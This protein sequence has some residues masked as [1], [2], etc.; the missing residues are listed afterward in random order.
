M[1]SFAFPLGVCWRDVMASVMTL[2][3]ADAQTAGDFMACVMILLPPHYGPPAISNTPNSFLGMCT[4]LEFSFCNFRCLHGPELY[5]PN[6]W[7][8]G[9]L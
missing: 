8:R 1:R 2:L 4:V 5:M 6:V 9:G 3:S 7:L